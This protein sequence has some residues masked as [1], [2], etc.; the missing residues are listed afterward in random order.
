[1]GSSQEHM[2]GKIVFLFTASAHLAHAAPALCLK[3]NG[4][5]AFNV[6][7]IA[8][9][10]H[11]ILI[12][13]Q[14]DLLHIFYIGRNFRTAFVAELLSFFQLVRLNDFQNFMA[15]GQD[16]LQIIDGT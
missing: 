6:T 16:A 9:G 7:V 8:D 3:V 15:I 4:S 2:L 13:N 11:N 5:L 12:R 1:M 14:V 10:D